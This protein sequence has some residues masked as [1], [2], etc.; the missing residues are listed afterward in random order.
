M[1]AYK[2]FKKDLTCMGFQF[3][4][5]GVNRTEQAN[6][7]ENGFHC[8]ENPLDCLYYYRDWEN[9][10]YYL[11]EASGDLDEDRDDSKISCTRLRLLKRLELKDLLLHAA[12]YM[13]KYPK[14]RWNSFV[15]REEGTAC[16]GF[17]VVRGKNPRASGKKGD[18]LVLVQEEAADARI[19]E[20]GIFL[21][22]G[23]VYLPDTWYGVSGREKEEGNP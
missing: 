17:A 10:V 15:C 1:V 8:A 3:Q 4:E 6:C 12:A 21:I 18:I 7:Q 19:R 16:Q 20:V 2:G 23:K 22:D 5:T 13:A 11:V 14:R 9:S